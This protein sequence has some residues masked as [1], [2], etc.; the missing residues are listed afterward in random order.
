MSHCVHYFLVAASLC[1]LKSHALRPS[2]GCENVPDDGIGTNLEPG[3][4]LDFMR[5]TVTHR[6]TLPSNYDT[7][8]P[9]PLMLYFHGQGENYEACGDRCTT[10]APGKGFV[11]LSMTGYGG[12]DLSSWNFAGSSSSPGPEGATCEA[13]ATDL[14]PLFGESSGCD[15]SKAD[16]CWWTTCKDSVGQVISVLDEIES[17]ICVDLDQIWAVGYSNGGMFTFELAADKRSSERL[18]GIVPIVG[19]PHHGFSNGPSVDL[20]MFGMFG[21]E[22]TVV[23]AISN[24]DNPDKTLDTFNGI[25]YGG[26]WYYTAL[27]KVM[28][29]WTKGNGCEGEGQ[30]PLGEDDFG[31]S[32]FNT[33]TCTQGCNERKDGLRVVGCLFEGGHVFNL[34][35]IWEPA[36]NFMLTSRKESKSSKKKGKTHCKAK[37]VKKDKKEKALSKNSKKGSSKAPKTKRD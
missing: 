19:L 29:D 13:G 14:C 22:D 36:F 20:P 32:M 8:T 16:N 23:P 5:D 17:E 37:S 26:G 24:T 7:T 27:T 12:A 9:P 3:D 4:S 34:D 30:D 21:T 10:D 11:S 25:Y 35:A 28:S 33:L 15:C 1:I 18:A 2:C 6:L 31:T